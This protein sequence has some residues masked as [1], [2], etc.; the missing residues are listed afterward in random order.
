MKDPRIKDFVS[1]QVKPKKVLTVKE[2]AIEIIKET[3][4]Y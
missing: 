1:L 3:I 4:A 2:K